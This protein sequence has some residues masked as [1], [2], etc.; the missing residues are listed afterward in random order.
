MK[1]SGGSEGGFVLF[2]IGF[3]LSALSL[4]LFFDSVIATTDVGLLTGL[5]RGQRGQGGGVGGQSLTTSMGI[6]FIPFLLGV[7]ALFYDAKQVWGWWLTYLGIALVVVEILSHLRFNMQIKTTHLLGMIA[8]FAAGAGLMLRSYKDY[9]LAI[10]E[11]ENRS[12][13]GDRSTDVP[14]Q[15]ASRESK[16]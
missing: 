1:G 3:L 10:D 7:I 14:K 6:I 2:G 13:A 5:M 16:S 4:Y 12:H 8:L 11:L 15:T 9:D